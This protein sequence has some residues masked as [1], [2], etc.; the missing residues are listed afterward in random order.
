M[1][2]DEKAGKQED[3]RFV[4]GP[5]ALAAVLPSVVRSAFRRRNPAVAHLA[6]DWPSV[7]G[8]ALAAVTA[9]KKLFS[10][11]LSVA[12]S[13]PVALELQ[14]LS[15]LLIERINRHFGRVA[16]T[17]LRFVQ[18]FAPALATALPVPPVTADAEAARA[19][20][21][22]PEG[23]LRAALERLGRVALVGNNA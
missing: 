19:V 2:A 18:D 11:T 23:P 16:V 21:S 9:P 4:Y 12:A 3:E 22:L 8:P 13:G 17:R 5:R 7:V 14:H 10:G 6:E 15:G 20:Q 1:G